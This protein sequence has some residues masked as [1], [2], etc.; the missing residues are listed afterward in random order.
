ML[1]VMMCPLNYLHSFPRLPLSVLL[2]SWIVHVIDYIMNSHSVHEVSVEPLDKGK[3]RAEDATERTPLLSNGTSQASPYYDERT[4]A[5]A[6]E[7]SSRR[8]RSWLTVIFLT[9]LAFCIFIFVIGALLAWSYAAK[10]STSPEKIVQEAFVFHGPESVNVINMTS[11]GGVWVKVEGSLGVD[12]GSVIGVNSNPK[13]DGFLGSLWKSLG[14]WVVGRLDQVT[15]SLSRIGIVSDAEPSIVLGFIEA[16]PMTVLLTTN[17]PSDGSWLTP[18]SITLRI[19][20]TNDTNALMHFMRTSWQQRS[21]ALRIDV[22]RASFRGG[23]LDENSWRSKLHKDILDVR[24]FLRVESRFLKRFIGVLALKAI[25][26]TIARTTSAWRQ[27]TI[28][29]RRRPGHIDII[30]RI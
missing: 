29:L 1:N 23:S 10:I 28:S 12:A 4:I 16:P 20:P 21:F 17:P 5:A 15:V 6:P 25:S 24:S 18:V 22:E 27:S 11:T 14:R 30:R 26:S 3:G 7:V 19:Q 2:P 13:Q 9:S 8:L